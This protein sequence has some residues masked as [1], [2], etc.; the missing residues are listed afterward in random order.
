MIQVV[1]VPYIFLN[2]SYMKSDI[3]RDKDYASKN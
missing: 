2:E 3:R 1:E